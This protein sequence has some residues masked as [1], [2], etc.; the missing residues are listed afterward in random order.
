MIFFPLENDEFFD[1]VF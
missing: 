1:R